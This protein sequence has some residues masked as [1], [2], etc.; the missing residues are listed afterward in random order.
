MGSERW[1]RDAFGGT[2]KT[3]KTIAVTSLILTLL[4]RPAGQVISQASPQIA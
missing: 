1:Y 2:G 4:V 3:F